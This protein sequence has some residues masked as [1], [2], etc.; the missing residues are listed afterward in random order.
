MEAL[1]GNFTGQT[2]LW[3]VFW[4]HNF[5]FGTIVNLLTNAFIETESSAFL[6]TWFAIVG[7]WSIWVFAGLW[8]CA[9]NVKHKFWGYIVRPFTVLCVGFISYTLFVSFTA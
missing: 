3:V 8:Q 2:K 5:A 6:Y 4:I 9:F 7:L 1:K